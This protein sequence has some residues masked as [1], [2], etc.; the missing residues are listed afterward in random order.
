MVSVAWGESESVEEADDKRGST[1]VMPL[2]T[3]VRPSAK[4]FP[5][6][7]IAI[8]QNDTILILQEQVDVQ[9]NEIGNLKNNKISLEHELEAT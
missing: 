8:E 3:K 1:L 4:N 6:K 5:Y 9:E 2:D 7:Q